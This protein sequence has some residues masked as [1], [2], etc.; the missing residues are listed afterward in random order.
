MQS[1]TACPYLFC[2]KQCDRIKVNRLICIQ[3]H[4]FRL[5][6]KYS[7]AYFK[8]ILPLHTH[9][10]SRISLLLSRH[11]EHVLAL[12]LSLQ[13]L[14]SVL[15]WHDKTL[16]HFFFALCYRSNA[17]L[18]IFQ[19]HHAPHMTMAQNDI[20]LQPAFDNFLVFLHICIPLRT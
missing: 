15:S 20:I 16:Q 18:H 12:R 6:D 7:N 13:K 1:R 19:I 17:L 8:C 2:E 5:S 11:P 9:I 10:K 3:Y 14:I 4:S